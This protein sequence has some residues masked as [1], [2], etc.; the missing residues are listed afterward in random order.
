MSAGIDEL[1]RRKN[2]SNPKTEGTN[3][4]MEEISLKMEEYSSRMEEHS[5][6]MDE[7]DRWIDDNEESLLDDIS[8]LVKI[9]SI[10]KRASTQPPYGKECAR[11]LEQMLAMGDRYGFSTDNCDGY[12]GSIFFG[13][14]VQTIGIWGHLDVVEAGNEWIYPSFACTKKGDYI[15]GRGVQDNKGPLV[16][17]LYAMRYLKE[18][19]KLKAKV[20]LIFGCNEENGMDDIL[21]YMRH[22]KIPDMS[23]V[24][25]CGFPVCRGEKG[26]CHLFIESGRL[27]GEILSIE[28]GDA[29]NIVPAKA[30]AILKTSLENEQLEIKAAGISGHAAFPEHTQNAIGLL[31][32]KLKGLLTEEAGRKNMEFLEKACSDGY[33]RGLDIACEDAISGALT[34]NMGLLTLEAGVIKAGLDIRY[35]VTVPV[36][37][38]IERIGEV[39]KNYHWSVSKI[40]DNPPYHIDKDHPLVQKLMEAY[41]EE[42]GNTEEAY[43]MGGGTYARKIP[44]A[45]GFGPGLPMNISELGLPSGHGG[46]HSADEVQSIANLK[47]A[48]RI[49][50][51]AIEKLNNNK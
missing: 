21:Y 18:K 3:P 31:A 19:E 25:D 28:G 11:A 1:Y 4:K 47:K 34:C 41:H 2:E 46:C 39:L 33:G 17:A 12:C 15:I 49:Y 8:S 48:I 45:V 20:L 10:A 27:Q 51:K 13:D 6:K 16:A 7:L 9:P 5:P 42:T 23:F 29:L 26:I 37:T 44:G 43:L 32:K 24:A 50:V 35:P 22:R 40:E 38:I 36:E 30:G 14:E